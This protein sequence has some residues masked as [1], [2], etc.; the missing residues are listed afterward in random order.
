MMFEKIVWFV[1]HAAQTE[2]CATKPVVEK[3]ALRGKFRLLSWA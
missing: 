2:V 3:G 1:L